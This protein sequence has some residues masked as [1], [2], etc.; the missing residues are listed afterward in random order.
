MADGSMIEASLRGRLKREVRVGD[1]VV[2]GDRV[3]VEPAPSPAGDAWVIEAVEPRQSSIVRRSGPGRKPK[4]VAANVDRVVVVVALRSPDPRAEVIDRMLVLAEADQ[5]PAVIVLNKIDLPRA[6]EIAEKLQARFEASGYTCIETSAVTNEGIDALRSVLSE[7]ISA[8]IGPSGVGKSSLLNALDP[9]LEL[10]TGLLS[11]KLERGRHTT[12]SA[13]LIPLQHGGLVADTPGFGEVGVWGVDAE[14]MEQC[15]PEILARSGECRFR[16]CSH[17][18]EPGCAVR[19]AVEAG[20]IDRERLDVYGLL[21]DE[22]EMD[23][24]RER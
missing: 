2:I 24:E 5:I 4:V 1:R 21:R 14:A 11:R 12:V 16:G 22:A 3:R 20:E 7:G 19:E 8:F 6:T 15:F 10:R 17:R 13:R 18:H 23:R 9:T